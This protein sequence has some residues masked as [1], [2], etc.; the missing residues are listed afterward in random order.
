M[1]RHVLAGKGE[2][3]GEEVIKAGAAAGGNGA[4]RSSNL[5]EPRAFL[6]TAGC[7]GRCRLSLAGSGGRLRERRDEAHPPAVTHITT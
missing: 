5:T 7:F 4:S 1:G 3:E 2:A 6:C